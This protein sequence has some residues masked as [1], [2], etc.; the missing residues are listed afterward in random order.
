[1]NYDEIRDLLKKYNWLLESISPLN[2][3][4]EDGEHSAQNFAAEVT[5]EYFALVD[6][7]NDE[8][9]KEDLMSRFKLIQQKEKNKESELPTNN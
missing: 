5:I 6:M 9:N 2:I 8:D 1:M 4:S 3:R 7:S